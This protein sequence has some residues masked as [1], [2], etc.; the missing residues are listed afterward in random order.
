ML[1]YNVPLGEYKDVS[2]DGMP[3]PEA[4]ALPSTVTHMTQLKHRASV[5][6]SVSVPKSKSIAGIELHD[7][8]AL[9]MED[10]FGRSRAIGEQT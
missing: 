4:P 3:Y 1:Q 10:L 6:E 8:A 7:E 2:R 5:H 9:L